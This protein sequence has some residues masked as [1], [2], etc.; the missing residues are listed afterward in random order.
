MRTRKVVTFA[1][2]TTNFYKVCKTLNVKPDVFLQ[3]IDETQVLVDKFI[4]SYRDGTSSYI[5]KKKKMDSLKQSQAN[6][7]H[8][9]KAIKSFIVANGIRIPPGFL[10]VEEQNHDYS[11]I[12][13]TD[14][15]FDQA[16]EFMS[17]YSEN[18]N[19]LF[20][21]HFEMGI[22]IDTLFTMKPK[23]EKR[24]V[25]INDKQCEYYKA[26]IYE[27]KQNKYYEKPIITPNARWI[28]KNLVDGQRLHKFTNI[29]EGKKEYNNCLRQ[30]YIHLKKISPDRLTQENYEIGTDE[31]YFVNEPS[32]V[33]R[34]SCVHRLMRMTGYR[35]D[36]VA[37][38]FWDNP[39]TLSIYQSQ[40]LDE[41]IQQGRCDFCT[42]LQ[43]PDPKY[44]IFDKLQCAIAFHNGYSN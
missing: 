6:A 11:R 3:S 40:T 42:P 22:R 5:Y 27:K 33:G 8:Y 13:L 43:T 10:L 21:L 34:H 14:Y 38:L 41:I 12:M 35:S 16:I 26:I 29:Q 23:W 37:S 15:E 25:T 20:I 4:Q 9:I 36:V 28:I 24:V 18:I 1:T 2:L 7:L 44:K 19:N 30:L 31:W 32:H 17:Q 39:T